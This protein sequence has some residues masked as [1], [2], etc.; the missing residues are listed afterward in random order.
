MINL[1]TKQVKKKETSQGRRSW[2]DDSC[3]ERKETIS[4]NDMKT[5][6]NRRYKHS[7]LINIIITLAQEIFFFTVKQFCCLRPRPA[8]ELSIW[9][10]ENLN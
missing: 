1:K 2:S 6:P 4:R 3:G 7:D 10:N 5:A 8:L 9:K